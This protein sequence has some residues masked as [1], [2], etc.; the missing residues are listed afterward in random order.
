[1]QGPISCRARELGSKPMASESGA[2]V[3]SRWFPVSFPAPPPHPLTRYFYKWK[4]GQEQA[5]A[6]RHAVSGPRVHPRRRRLLPSGGLPRHSPQSRG[7]GA[8]GLGGSPGCSP[9]GRLGTK[10]PHIHFLKG[11]LGRPL[12]GAQLEALGGDAAALWVAGCSHCRSSKA[13]A[14]NL[15]FILPRQVGKPPRGFFS[16]ISG[17]SV[18]T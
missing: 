10:E 5:C 4:F 11:G 3:L 8:R 18:N 17:L 9:Q 7:T 2:H 13:G 15:L 14:G 6:V 12:G 1:M 16:K